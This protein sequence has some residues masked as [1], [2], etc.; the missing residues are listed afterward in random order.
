M[1]YFI[2]FLF[3]SL[4]FAF[5]VQGAE[6]T[7]TNSLGME[8][9]LIPAGSFIMGTDKNDDVEGDAAPRHQVTISQPFY[10]G[11]YEV[12]QAQWEALMG[13]NPSAFQG[14]NNPA[15]QITWKAAQEFIKHLNQKE[16]HNRYRLP[17]E[18]EWEY[19]ARAGASGAYYFGDKADDLGLYAWYGDNSADTTHPVGQKEPNPWG[20]YDLHGNVSEWV[21]DWYG[22]SYYSHSPGADP[23]GPSSGSER[24]NRGGSWA[25]YAW[26]CRVDFRGS[27]PP[28]DDKLSNVYG[29]RLALTL[30]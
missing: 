15:E 11:K 22:E 13:N 3:L 25:H 24:V 12:T 20:L 16:G 27:C 2:F 28:D 10:L 18:A 8:F 21:E 9:I 5:P 7:Y 6:K 23:T 30:E 26:A 19:A 1:R 29:L 14:K 17:T 4:L